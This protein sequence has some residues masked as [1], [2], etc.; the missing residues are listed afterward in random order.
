MPFIAL[1]SLS[2]SSIYYLPPHFLLQAFP[3]DVKVNLKL[4]KI[5]PLHAGWLVKVYTD[6]H[7]RGSLIF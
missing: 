1:W 2:W 4:S 3:R 6:M 5:K 7:D